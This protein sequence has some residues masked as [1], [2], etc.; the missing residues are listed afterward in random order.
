M[1]DSGG[2]IAK[3]FLQ[4]VPTTKGF[5]EALTKDIDGPSEE[6][7]RSAGN[8]IGT[9]LKA[10]LVAV[11]V[12]KILK[13][14]ITA[15][16]ELEQNL[17]GTEA[18]FGQFADNI[19]NSAQDAYLNMGLSASDYMATANKMGSLF[20]GSG[21][22]QQRA[23]DLTSSAMQRAADVASV[24]GLD[25]TMAM[26]SIAGAAKGNFT[27]MDNLGVA[28][29]AT[30]LQAYALEK[31][32]NFDWNT[33][34]N[35]EKAELAMKMFMDKTTQ[36]AGNFARESAET[37][38]GSLGAM[39][40]SWQNVLGNM[41]TG[42]DI[43][44]PLET[45]STSIINFAKNALPMVGNVLMQL[46]TVLVEVLTWA[47]PHVVDMGLKVIASLVQG[48]AEALPTLIPAMVDAITWIVQ[49]I[50]DNIPIIIEAGV[51][52]IQGL[53]EGIMNSI[54]ILVERIPEIVN[55]L[56]GTLLTLIP[57]IIDAGIKLFVALVQALP[58]IIMEIVSV[59]PQI[60]DS[61][62]TTL[63]DN[64][65][66]LIDAGVQLFV[67]LVENLPLIISVLVSKI[68]SIISSLISGF[69]QSV[70]KLVS[71]GFT[72][73][74]ALVQNL[75]SI[76]SQIVGVI[77]QIISGIVSGFSNGIS[78]LF[79]IGGQMMDGLKNGI[80]N[81]ASR[82]VEGAMEVASNILGGIKGFF[83][84]RSPSRVM[85]EVGKF[86]DEG[87]AGG[88]SDNM[89]PIT[90]AMDAVGD[91]ANQS[92]ESQIG[93]AIADPDG[94]N[95]TVN[96]IEQQ[97]TVSQGQKQ[98]AVL[99]FNFGNRVFEAFVEDITDVQNKKIDL[100]LKY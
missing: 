67:A 53:I 26:E 35:A 93:F 24:M 87:L 79:N 72:L 11:G 59:L 4:I 3:S 75:P 19:K 47:V 8:K 85:A 56:V 98:P 78:Q 63:L 23:L 91:I 41:A 38:S 95:N 9:A 27:M 1:A 31:G 71:A 97:L 43:S 65:P 22:E 44:A 18:V 83:G 80:A 16:G 25:T 7:G 55:Q 49:A 48:I 33:A 89:K 29:N 37:F 50:V 13:D 92:F 60:I 45:L 36:Y 5:K 66:L 68:P 51:Q 90:K 82:V 39:K 52:L 28:M 74:V 86:L 17:G 2:P 73:F 57:L 34:S 30:T 21:V 10:A 40:A 70:P 96:S 99:T 62:I 54:P 84:I 88:I 15:G 32:I 12:G 81:A 42:A 46:P 61:V 77:P 14:A 64:L 6:V 58:Q 76:I 100:Q 69:M 20:Q 94:F